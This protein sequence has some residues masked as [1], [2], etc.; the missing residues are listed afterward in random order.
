[1]VMNWGKLLCEAF[2]N[3][4]YFLGRGQNE[5]VCLVKIFVGCSKLSTLTKMYGQHRR[6]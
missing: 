4:G 3:D 6:K 1:M 2:G 5:Y